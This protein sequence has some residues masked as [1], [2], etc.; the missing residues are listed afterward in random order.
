[1]NVFLGS[2]ESGFKKWLLPWPVFALRQRTPFLQ[3]LPNIIVHVLQ[4]FI[5]VAR[6]WTLAD[7]SFIGNNYSNSLRDYWTRWRVMSKYIVYNISYCKKWRNILTYEYVVK[8]FK[9]N[10]RMKRETYFSHLKSINF[11]TTALRHRRIRN[12][13]KNYFRNY[14]N[15]KYKNEYK[16]TNKII[17]YFIW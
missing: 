17:R 15:Q 1:M 14:Q 4:I 3:L 2:L 6:N 13:L 7:S 5:G 9:I 8:S 12:H 16:L 10:A 11:V